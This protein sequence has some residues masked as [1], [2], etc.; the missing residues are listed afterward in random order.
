VQ[1]AWNVLDEFSPA[2]KWDWS[3][4]I[5]MS[6][7]MEGEWTYPNKYRS[8]LSARRCASIVRSRYVILWS[9]KVEFHCNYIHYIGFGKFG[10]WRHYWRFL[11]IDNFG[12]I[13]RTRFKIV[14]LFLAKIILDSRHWSLCV[15]FYV[16]IYFCHVVDKTTERTTTWLIVDY[17]HNF[18]SPES[19]NTF[20][21]C[22]KW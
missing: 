10:A 1:Y 18:A 4:V 8:I 13:R 15:M 20:I 7:E 14:T 22:I 12:N 9:R 3:I 5:W 17:L 2:K 6:M 19:K 16:F 21:E 11:D